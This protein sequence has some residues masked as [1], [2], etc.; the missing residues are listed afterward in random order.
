MKYGRKLDT[1]VLIICFNCTVLEF[2]GNIFDI[3]IRIVIT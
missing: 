2:G 3:K 1:N